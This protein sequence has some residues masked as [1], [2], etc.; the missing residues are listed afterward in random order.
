MAETSSESPSVA[1]LG[2]GTMGAA[3]A[4][5]IAAA[6]MPVRVWNR[7]RGTAEAL[8]DVA[9][10]CDT[11]AEAVTGASV[12]VTVLHDAASVEETMRAAADGLPDDPASVV[13]MQ[14]ATVGVA[15]AIA[16]EELADELGVRY[17]DAPVLGTKK[18]AEDGTLTV[19]GSG[20]S[21]P[22]ERVL[23]VCQAIAA[24]T[25]WVGPAVSGSRLKLAVNSW[26]ATVIEGVAESLAFTRALGLDPQLLLDA[27]K[28]GA[29]DAPYVQVKGAM[30]LAGEFPPSFTV[31]GVVKDIGLMLEAAAATDFEPRLLPVILEQFEAAA[32]QDLGDRD[33]AAVYRSL[34]D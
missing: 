27:L 4:R 30:M 11:P 23:P 22:A 28:G 34:G 25:M 17:V 29:L 9:D 2:T 26:V 32:G 12:V 5:N 10:V 7:T 16:L 24:R 15:G 3:M 13:W 21:D 33:M 1:L 6:G 14:S 31:D 8:A 19:L 18:P 20:D